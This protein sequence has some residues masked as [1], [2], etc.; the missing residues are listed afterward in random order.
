[1]LYR[2]TLLVAVCALIAIASG[3]VVTSGKEAASGVTGSLVADVHRGMA[4]GVGVLVL[5][6]GGLLWGTKRGSLR[7]L[8]AVVVLLAGADGGIAL[9]PPLDPSFAVLHAWLAPVF[10]TTLVA[11]AL[12]TWP[13]WSEEPELVDDRGL[14]F[15]R[16]LAIAAPPLVLVQIV[17]GAM[18]RHKLTSVFWHM[19][20][21]MLVSLATLVAS[22]V[23]MQQ[24]P[25]HR[26]LRG[27]AIALMSVVLVQVT[28]GVAA[29]TMELLEME[30]AVVLNIATVSHVVVGNLTLAASLI[31]AM[32]VQRCIRLQS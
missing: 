11:V 27:S 13:R 10:F 19:G 28:L 21:A 17:L 23:V 29:F 6:L 4:I 26:A 3:A 7:L 9:G 31:F 15:L 1:V 32:Q 24:Y 22:M 5:A 20:G 16:P 8:A 30:N 25:E 12:L 14:R 18:Y 2:F